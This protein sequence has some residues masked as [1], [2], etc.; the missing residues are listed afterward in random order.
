MRREQAF[1]FHETGSLEQDEI[2]GLERKFRRNFRVMKEGGRRKSGFDCGVGDLQGLRADAEEQIRVDAGGHGSDEPVEFLTFV[3][4][5]AHIA[6][7]GHMAALRGG[8]GEGFEGGLHA[9]GIG[10]V[11]IVDV[12]DSVFLYD[13]PTHGGT[14][15]GLDAGG[16]LFRKDAA[17]TGGS[18]SQKG[19]VDHVD[20]RNARFH[21]VCEIC[22]FFAD[23]KRADR[24]IEDLRDKIGCTGVVLGENGG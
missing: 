8:F 15:G 5:F 4:E 1:E 9:G 7:D 24:F 12:T 18:D 6:E 16:D 2:A 14:R 19:V 17:Y 13:L 22:L 11:G 23:G 21:H 10:I 3:A 20:A